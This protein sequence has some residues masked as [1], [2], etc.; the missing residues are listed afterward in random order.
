M[1][2]ERGRESFDFGNGGTGSLGA[3]GCGLL[4]R[5]CAG[6]DDGRGWRVGFRVGSIEFID[7]V[8][9]GVRAGVGELVESV[10]DDG[11]R[12][13]GLRLGR[14]RA[15]RR[16]LQPRDERGVHAGLRVRL[17]RARNVQVLGAAE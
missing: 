11:G 13:D 9:L 12:C 3:F 15:L 6:D 17:L 8:E 2:G 1:V 7:C 14:W 10:L 5:R 4:E 16:S